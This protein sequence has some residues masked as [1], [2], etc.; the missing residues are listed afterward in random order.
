LKKN[1]RAMSRAHVSANIFLP[2]LLKKQGAA[3]IAFNG[4]QIDHQ[5]SLSW[6]VL[7]SRVA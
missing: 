6:C 7:F 3:G 5:Y 2:R 1:P 4:V